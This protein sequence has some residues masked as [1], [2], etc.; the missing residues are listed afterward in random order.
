MQGYGVHPESSAGRL[1]VGRVQRPRLYEQ[2]VAQILEYMRQE[3]LAAGDKLPAERDLA[4]ALGVSR[5]TL[6]Q[7]LVA[8]EVTG[9]IE[10]QHGNGA[11]VLASHPTTTVLRGL[12]EHLERL[13]DVIEARRTIEARLA[14]L[15]AE[16]RDNEDLHRIDTALELMSGEINDGQRGLRGDEA[17]HGA[18]AGAAKSPVLALLLRQIEDLVLESRTESLGQPG[19]PTQSLAS[20]RE[21][22]R[23]I[24]SRDS[25]AAAAAMIAHIDLVS[26]IALS[27]D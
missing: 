11:V 17:F 27:R 7:A 6:S 4:D 5:A 19:R 16:R 1:A 25:E 10:V 26:D 13:P 21:I 3:G 23:A 20:H 14:A 8:L 12:R 15:A 22:A 2:L 24:R 9:V 18:V